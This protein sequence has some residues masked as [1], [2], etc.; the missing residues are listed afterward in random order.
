MY[1][2]IYL[3]CKHSYTKDS[4]ASQRYATIRD[5]AVNKLRKWRYLD[6]SMLGYDSKGS[7]YRDCTSVLGYDSKS[8]NDRDCT[9][10]HIPSL[11]LTQP[12]RL[13]DSVLKLVY[14]FI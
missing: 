8:R 2:Y 10:G 14:S 12:T 6:L 9:S 13:V 5:L 3:A 4:I 1:I 7:T 11:L